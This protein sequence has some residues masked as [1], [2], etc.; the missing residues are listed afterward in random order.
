MII[1]TYPVETIINNLII[2]AGG[3]IGGFFICMSLVNR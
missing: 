1:E 2:M 3:F